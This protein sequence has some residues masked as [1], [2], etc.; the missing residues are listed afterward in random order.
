MTIGQVM[1]DLPG[2]PSALSVRPIEATGRQLHERGIQVGW[3]RRDLRDPR[4]A[5]VW[6]DV[7]VGLEFPDRVTE[8][9]LPI[10]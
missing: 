2:R 6:R 7:C 3:K 1:H 10:I 4:F 5:L 9:H 8:I